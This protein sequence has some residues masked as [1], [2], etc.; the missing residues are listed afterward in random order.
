M[1]WSGEA[2]QSVVNLTGCSLFNPNTTV[3][4]SSGNLTLTSETGKANLQRSNDL[5]FTVTVAGTSATFLANPVIGLA[6]QSKLAG[7]T[8]GELVGTGFIPG[9]AVVNGTTRQAQMAIAFGARK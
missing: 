2:R 8:S 4:P 3:V 6:A 5:K 9:S 1:T 7:P